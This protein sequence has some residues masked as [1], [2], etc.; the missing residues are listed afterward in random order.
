[1]RL[2]LSAEPE[3]ASLCES[4]IFVHGPA[5]EP[6]FGREDGIEVARLA[7]VAGEGAEGEL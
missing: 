1:M 3:P 6:L 7:Q 4:A 5:T 2:C